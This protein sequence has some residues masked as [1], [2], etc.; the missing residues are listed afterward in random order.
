MKKV[1][2]ILMFMFAAVIL[3]AQPDP[4][5]YIVGAETQTTDE[6]GWAN[7]EYVLVHLSADLIDPI[8]WV[9]VIGDFHILDDETLVPITS[10]DTGTASGDNYF[11]LHIDHA[12]YV[13]GPEKNDLKLHYINSGVDIITE[14]GAL[15]NTSTAVNIDD[16]IDPL[17]DIYELSSDFTGNQ[18]YA[19]AGNT[20]TLDFIANENLADIPVAPTVTFSVADADWTSSIITA[21]IGDSAKA[22][23]ASFV[24]PTVALNGKINFYVEFYDVHANFSTLGPLDEGTDGKSVWIKNYDPT[25]TYVG[26]GFDQDNLPAANVTGDTDDLIYLWSVFKT[27]QEGIDG[28]ASGGHVN[29]TTGTYAED[30]TIDKTLELLPYENPASDDYDDVTLKGLAKVDATLFPLADANIDVLATGV[31]IHDFTIE[32]PD[33]VVGFYSSGI[34]VGGTNATIYHNTFLANIVSSTDD[35]S[36]SI[37]TYNGVDI[38]GLNIYTNTFDNIVPDFD[39]DWGYEAI[40][41]NLG[42]TGNVNIEDNTIQGACFRGITAQRSNVTITGNDITTS[43]APVSDDWNTPG[44]WVGIW[45]YTDISDITIINNAVYGSDSGNGYNRGIRLGS[46]SGSTFTNLSVTGNEIYYNKNG[47]Y[48]QSTAGI[49]ITGNAIV[50][51]TAY[52]IYNTA[53]TLSAENNYWGS[54]NGPVHVDNTFNVGSQGD[55]SSD[56]VDYVPWYDTNMTSNSFAPI[57]EDDGGSDVTVGYYSSFQ[58]AIDG[59]TAGNTISCVAG[60]Y[61]ENVNVDKSLTLVGASSATVTVNA[62]VSSASVFNV[63]ANSVS[64]SEFTVSGASGGGQAGIYLGAGVSLC[65]IFD[66]ILTGNF[67]G[68][69]LGAGSNL[70]TLT[71]NILTANYQGFEVYIA[72]NNTFTSNIAN[73]NTNY[74]FKIDSG[75]NNQFTSNIANSNTKF[76]FYVVT[77]DGGGCS[78]TTFTNNTANLNTTYGIRINGG[79]GTTLTGNTFDSNGVSGIRFKETMTTVTMTG[80]TVTNNPIGIE[81]TDSVDDVSTWAVNYNH[82]VGNTA[83]GIS[84]AAV[85]GTLDAE[86]NWWGSANGPVHIDNTFN[87]GSQGDESTNFVDYVP[88][89]DTTMSGTSFWPVELVAADA[90]GYF[91][92]V[93]T[94]I[95]AAAGGE[96]IECKAGTY[97]EDFLVDKGLELEGYTGETVTLLGEQEVTSGSVFFDNFIFNPNGGTAIT[98]NSSAA[99]ID[100]TTIQNCTFDLTVGPSVGVYL[101]GAPTPQKVSNVT[102]QNNIFNGPGLMNCNPWKIGGWYGAN[103]SCEIDSVTFYNNEVNNASIP[104]NLVNENISNISITYNDF[105]G[106]DGVIYFWNNPASSPTGVLSNFVFENN[107]VPSS[108]SYG[109]AIGGAAVGGPTFTDANFGTGNR[110]NDNFFEITGTAYG[111]GAVYMADNYTGL[112]DAMDNWWGDAHGPT[113]ANSTYT[114]PPADAG[115]VVSDRVEFARWW[116]SGTNAI[117]TRGWEPDA[118]S[119]LFAPVKNVTR[120]TYHSSIQRAVDAATD[121]DVLECLAGTFAE[122]VT[123]DEAITLKGANYDI[124]PNTGTRGTETFIEVPGSAGA[125]LVSANGVVVNGFTIQASSTYTATGGNTLFAITGNDAEIKNNIFTSYTYDGAPFSTLWSNNASGMDINDNRFLTNGGT[126]GGSSDAAVDLYGGGSTTNHNQFRNNVLIHDNVGGGYGLAISSDSGLASYYDVEDNSFST[127]NSAIQVVDYTTTAGYG[128]NNVLIDGNT[129]DSG[130]Y[131]LWF[132][133]IAVDPGTG[134]SD[135]T[136]TNNYLT[137]NVRGINFQDGAANI[138]VSTFAVYYNDITGNTGYGVYNPIATSL[139]AE[140]NWWGH[141]TGPDPD[142]EGNNPH[143]YAAAGDKITDGVDFKPYW[144]TDTTTLTREYVRTHR[145]DPDGIDATNLAYSD[146]IQAGIDA[147]T[148]N[149]NYFYVEVGTGGSPYIENVVIDKLLS[150]NGLTGATIAPTTGCGVEIQASTVTVDNFIINTS[151]LDAH[152]IYISAGATGLTLT[153]NDITIGGGSTA[154]YADAGA[155]QTAKSSTWTISGNTLNAPAGVNLELYDVDV[156][157][158]DNNTFMNTAGSNVIVSSELF[159][160]AGFT[161]T[162]ND[163][164]GNDGGSMVAFVTDFQQYI[165]LTRPDVITTTMDDVTITGNTFDGWAARG[166]RIG[167][168]GGDVTNVVVNYN[169]FEGTGTALANQ[170]A[171]V[172]NAE[173]NW[174]DSTNGP[175]HD[176]NTFNINAQGCVVSDYVD[177]VPWYDTDMTTTSFAPVHRDPETDIAGWYYS[178]IQAAIDDASNNDDIWCQYGTFTED[179]SVPASV[180]GLTVTSSLGDPAYPSIQGIATVE[181]SLFPLAGPNIDIWG[182]STTLE[183]FNIYAPEYGVGYYSS[184]ICVGAQSVTIS[185]NNF[186]A[187]S[188]SNTADVCQSMQTYNGVDVSDLAIMYNSFTHK[189]TGTVGDWGYEAIYINPGPGTGPVTVGHNTLGGNLLRGITTQRSYTTIDN[190]AIYTDF[191]PMAEDWSTAGAWQGVNVNGNLTNVTVSNNNISGNV[192]DEVSLGFLEGIR[193]GAT[194]NIF[195]NFMITENSIYGNYYGILCKAA[196]GVTVTLNDIVD[197]TTYGVKND[198]NAEATDLSAENNWWGDATGPSFTYNYGLGSGDGDEIT[199]YVDYMPWWSA[200]GG[201]SYTPTVTQILIE[202]NPTSPVVDTYFDIRVAAADTFGILNPDYGNLVD[203][204]AN[205]AALTVPEEQLLVN[206]FIEITDGC[207]S[208]EVFAAVDNLTIYAW[209]Y[210]TNPPSYHSS[211]AN[212][213]IQAAAAPEPPTNVVAAD[214]PA[215]NGGWIHLDY[216]MSVNDPFHSAAVAPY[217][218]YYI[219]EI[220]WDITAGEDWQFLATIGCYNY[221][222]DDVTALLNAPASDVAYDY[223]MCSV[224]NDADDITRTKLANGPI[225]SYKRRDPFTDD[226]SQS[227]WTSGGSAAAADNLPAYA[228]IKVF[229]EGPYQAGETMNTDLLTNGLLPVGAPANAVDLVELQLRTTTTGATVKQY[230]DGY[231]LS[232]GSVVDENGNSS[233]P[234]FYTTDLEYYFVFIHRNHLDVMSADTHTFADLPS[235]PPTID[236]TVTGS[237]YLDGFK[238]VEDGVYAMYSGDGNASNLVNAADALSILENLNIVS[239]NS[240]DL[241]LSALTNPADAL[242]IIQNINTAGTV[243]ASGGDDA[244]VKYEPL[245][246]GRVD[247]DCTLSIQNAQVS[248]GL[249]SFDV[250]ITRNASWTANTALGNLFGAFSSVVVFNIS[251]NSFSNPQSS[252]YGCPITGATATMF[253]NKVQFELI[254]SGIEVPTTPTLLLTVTLTIDEPTN[255]AGLSWQSTDT[256]IYDSSNLGAPTLELLGSDDTTLPVILSSFTTA[257]IEDTPVIYWTTQS[258][259]GNAGW[260]L[261]RGEY[262]EAFANGEAFQINPELIEGAGTTSEP[263]DYTFEDPHPVEAGLE[264]WYTLESVCYNGETTTYGSRSLLIPESG[265][266]P[267]LPDYTALKNNYPNPF[268]PATEIAYAVKEG[269]VGTLTIFNIKGQVVESVKLPAGEDTY[270]WEADSHSSGVYFYKLQTNSYSKV[271]KMMLLK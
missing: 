10:G 40:Y 49:T 228:N 217:I 238:E 249:Y 73:S 182:A 205:H 89:Y 242:E 189:T 153:G 172:L 109:I 150:L 138:D 224:R 66:N 148:S 181:S 176:G 93:Q 244:I 188:A 141:V 142:I 29:V 59:A 167:D 195:T 125:L 227:V 124:S 187:T 6:T 210:M 191:E 64:M 68:I 180:T 130:K 134:I 102:M 19:E 200:S 160:L 57:L 18:Y 156:V 13:F 105:I 230:A 106:T 4:V 87:V 20:V 23:S 119:T 117:T 62:A 31:S 118:G 258:E 95:D 35:I 157:T 116:N 155:S 137:N 129:C 262:E 33:Y 92:S 3:L 5:A 213:V 201:P 123:I 170:D 97:T 255:T 71:S 179:F 99:P 229:L 11:W 55:P 140:K 84:N 22:W 236:L 164:Q 254:T 190:N 111:Y 7:V 178:S 235:D 41:I 267:Q 94:A 149:D 161:F 114:A 162:N 48:S 96:T 250:Y 90:S 166:L 146:I 56:F 76:G 197:N 231:V 193:I 126:L 50:N 81:I 241:N 186:Y 132:Y 14:Y 133:G 225:I 42:G 173:D 247:E 27:V 54:L 192:P 52:G 17:L 91:S 25:Y 221:G 80:N 86:D 69:W 204:S 88:W 271:K 100:G 243:P 26:D 67:D 256:A 53:G 9:D 145:P 207:I 169:S 47:I 165:T 198:D 131:G 15:Q 24:V 44:A 107:Y 261:Y 143:G 240:G 51:N 253:T 34:V 43:E 185:N 112:L 222:G 211:L 30:L 223:R 151:G 104:V 226:A 70:N 12:T 245:D 251:E 39:I 246:A 212:I 257:Y 108:N 98:I 36:Q 270:R 266:G 264:Y 215:D 184:G 16:G 196:T 144:G 174:W 214:V 32:A 65:N 268:N 136:V 135:V 154:I 8:P 46:G 37:Q 259:D 177:Y 209:E 78:N 58:T 263:T 158:I 61:T 175:D 163:V 202:L 127:Y 265:S 139:D 115:S 234:F 171:V 77:G 237:V 218:D 152:G 45:A 206:G 101:G 1:I 113:N 128:V 75:D 203:F 82:I 28:V 103:T 260:N 252:N 159:N 121:G 199:T 168:W 60:T 122:S 74:G 147:A 239:Y 2:L 120:T 194:G 232:D 79:S 208:T 85:A 110:I 83:Y 219:V 63:T 220:D 72:D 216:T 248:G 269:E 233:F 21:I 183:Y 38:S